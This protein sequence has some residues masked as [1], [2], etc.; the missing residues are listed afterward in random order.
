MLTA[1]AGS[2]GVPGAA[3]SLASAPVG[4]GQRHYGFALSGEYVGKIHDSLYGASRTRLYLSQSQNM[5]GGVFINDGA[6]HSY[7]HP[8][9]LAAAI[10]WV[11]SGLFFSGN[12]VSKSSP[13]SGF[14]AFSMS[15]RYI[16]RDLIGSCTATNGC[17]GENGSFRLW[18]TCYIEGLKSDAI[19]P[20]TRVKPCDR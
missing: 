6:S 19:R 4:F 7:T 13:F 11:V 1:C 5:L 15:G 12:G 14:F 20:E 3:S 16:Y 17:A 8:H 10:V 2:G 9:N 18:H